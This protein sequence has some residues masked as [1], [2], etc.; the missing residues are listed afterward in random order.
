[1]VVTFHADIPQGKEAVGQA[2]SMWASLSGFEYKRGHLAE[3]AAREAGL[4][5]RVAGSTK[6]QIWFHDMPDFYRSVDAVLMCSTTEA[7]GLPAMEGA[8]AGRLGV[9]PP[10]GNFP[11]HASRGG[12]VPAPIGTQRC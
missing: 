9:G 6:K 3:A 11:P 2:S 4:Q 1:D 8:A 7:A 12:G 10:V 5:F